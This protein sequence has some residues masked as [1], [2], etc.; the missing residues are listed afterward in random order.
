MV[1]ETGVV[2]LVV[3][4]VDDGLPDGVSIEDEALITKAAS[5]NVPGVSLSKPVECGYVF[6]V[7]H[8]KSNELKQSPELRRLVDI[9]VETDDC[10]ELV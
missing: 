4:N 1:V 10:V 5:L 6:C 9:V 3:R 7:P 2:F 8:E